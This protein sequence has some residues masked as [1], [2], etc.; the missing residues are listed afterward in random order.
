MK[1]RFCNID[2]EYIGY[3][4]RGI[5]PDTSPTMNWFCDNCEVVYF[6]KIKG[7]E[8]LKEWE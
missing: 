8:E 2:M 7:T 4:E 1:C 6:R 5:P 3:F